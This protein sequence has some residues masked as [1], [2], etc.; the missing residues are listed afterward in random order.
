MAEHP[1]AAERA[2]FPIL[3]RSAQLSS[4]SQSALSTPVDAAIQAYLASWRE[5][6]MAWARW[7]AALDAA[8]AAFARL[9][10]AQARDIAVMASVSD[11]A[12][13][14]A[15]SLD[16]ST[17]RPGIV[18]GEI[19]FPSL[20]HVWQAQHARG[21]EVHFVTPDEAGTIPPEAYARAI[22]ARTRLVAISHVAYANAFRHDLAAV[23]ALAHAQGAVFFVDAYQSL[24]ACCIDVERDGIDVLVSGTQ[25]YLLGL[26]G[27]AFMYVRPGLA[28]SLRPTHTGWFGRV[29]PF[30][31]DIHRLDYAEGA[32]RF[33]TGTPPFL[34]AAA[35]G[36][37]LELILNLGP[38]RIAAWVEHLS[39]VALEAADRHGL[40]VVSP[41][42]I[43][44]KGPHTAI[45]VPDSAALERRMAEAGYIVSARGPLIRVAPHFYNTEDEVAGAFAALARLK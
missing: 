23:A 18:L 17:G 13:S 7:G 26:P 28:E 12:S 21:A 35:A 38:E 3:S 6:G 15:H 11:L 14:F 4:C 27:I 30:A 2:L 5:Q 39:A 25:K 42:S 19:E 1:F 36:A 29:D 44:A 20:G 31:F 34:N 32:R 8:K 33:D 43:A 40:D 9:I 24:G 45:R 10:G 16:F 22:D 41:R 37:A